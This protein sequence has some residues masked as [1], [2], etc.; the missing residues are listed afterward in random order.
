MPLL[1]DMLDRI[2]SLPGWGI[3]SSENLA[4]SVGL[5][6][7]TGVSLSRFIYSLGIPCI[8]THA[9]QLIASS[10]KN[11]NAFINA[12]DEASTFDDFNIMDNAQH[13]F[14]L[15]TGDEAS[16]KVKGIGPVALSSLLAYSK[17]EVLMKAAKDLTKALTIHDDS[18]PQID[19]FKNEGSFFKD[20]SIVFTGALPISRTAAQNAVKARGAK[21]TP[22]T[23]SKSTTL[24]VVGEKGGKKAKQASEMGIQVMDAVE[25]MKLIGP[26]S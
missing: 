22:N 16:D 10:Y 23:I 19:D 7:S 3:V 21:S 8:G 18:A 11:V 14:A 24:V 2:A 1:L 17:E 25:F 9:S 15:L 6:A 26:E 13:P 20:L 5:V 12:L 4:N